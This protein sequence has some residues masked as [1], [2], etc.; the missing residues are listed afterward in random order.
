MVELVGWESIIN[1]AYPVYFFTAQQPF[2]SLQE[3]P[4]QTLCSLLTS[5]MLDIASNSMLKTS[6]TVSGTS[7]ADTRKWRQALASNI[8]KRWLKYVSLYAK[9]LE[10]KIKKM[11]FYKKVI[12]NLASH[13]YMIQVC[14]G[15]KPWI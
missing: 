4:K 3:A 14:P 2:V 9:Y 12:N 11:S 8:P 13:S 1:G 6:C 10:K 15:V 7:V 5:D